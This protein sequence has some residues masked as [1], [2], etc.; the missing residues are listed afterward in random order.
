[1][2]QLCKLTLEKQ[3][4]SHYH[5]Q[6]ITLLHAVVLVSFSE[7]TLH[8]HYSLLHFSWFRGGSKGP[9][10]PDRNQW[11]SCRAKACANRERYITTYMYTLKQCLHI[12]ICD[13]YIIMAFLF[14]GFLSKTIDKLGEDFNN[15]D[16]QFRIKCYNTVNYNYIYNCDYS[17]QERVW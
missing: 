15:Q 12:P 14:W 13:S 1:M 3:N 5:E 17:V 4:Y 11:D 8:G 10:A 9:E 7:H 16:S 2:I 6:P